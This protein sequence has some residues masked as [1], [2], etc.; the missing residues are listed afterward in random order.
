MLDG[1][2]LIYWWRVVWSQRGCVGHKKKRSKHIAH[3]ADCPYA[4]YQLMIAYGP[5]MDCVWEETGDGSRRMTAAPRIWRLRLSCTKA[6]TRRFL[7]L[8]AE[9]S[10]RSDSPVN[11]GVAMRSV[12]PTLCNQRSTG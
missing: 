4:H 8:H 10:F 6:T 1:G 2:S 5:V 7:R 3:R 11:D 12:E 9:S